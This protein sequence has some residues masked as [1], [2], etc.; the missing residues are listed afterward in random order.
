MLKPPLA[1]LNEE[2]FPDETFA[3]ILEKLDLTLVQE[4]KQRFGLSGDP[5]CI[6]ERLGKVLSRFQTALRNAREPAPSLQRFEIDR[7][8]KSLD[9]TLEA[10]QA[11]SKANQSDIDAEILYRAPFNGR[12]KFEEQLTYWDQNEA[13]MEKLIRRLEQASWAIDQLT[14]KRNSEFYQPKRASN[15]P[16]DHFI[17][18]LTFD[19]ENGNNRN[20]LSYCYYSP[21]KEGYT[22]QYYDFVVYM[23]NL[24]APTSYHS[25]L[26]LGKRIVRVLKANWPKDT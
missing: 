20:A 1:H 26:A 11:V 8:K 17:E 7:L 2:G 15:K 9:R 24:F 12:F 14:A 4:I 6:R 13:S 23:L 5:Q 21:N 16:L 10:L 25:E 3:S 22:G 18:D 19:F